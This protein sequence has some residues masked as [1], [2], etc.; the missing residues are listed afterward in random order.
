MWSLGSLTPQT[1]DEKLHCSV[2]GFSLSVVGNSVEQNLSPNTSC[3]AQMLW[4]TISNLLSVNI[5]LEYNCLT[6]ENGYE[7]IKA[8]KCSYICTSLCY[9]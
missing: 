6:E 5:S 7:L 8:E 1:A 9:L 4:Q 2:L 3:L